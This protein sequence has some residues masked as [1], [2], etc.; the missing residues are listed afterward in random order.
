ME[1]DLHI[2]ATHTGHVRLRVQLGPGGD[3]DGWAL[4]Q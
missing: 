1:N 2:V 3:V 4:R